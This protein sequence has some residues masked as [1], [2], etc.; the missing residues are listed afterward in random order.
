[1]SWYQGSQEMTRSVSS[2]FEADAVRAQIV[3]QARWVTATPCGKRVEP[4]EYCR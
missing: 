1:M 2:T 4:L 3:E